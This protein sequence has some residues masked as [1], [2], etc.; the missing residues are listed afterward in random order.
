MDRG[1]QEGGRIGERRKCSSGSLRWRAAPLA[2]DFFPSSPSIADRER[3]R[4]VPRR[5]NL[6]ADMI[7]WVTR[8]LH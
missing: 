8:R 7:R 1:T 2:R 6:I 4:S 5:G 3:E